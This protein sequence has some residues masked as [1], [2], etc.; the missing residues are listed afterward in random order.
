MPSGDSASWSATARSQATVDWE[1]DFSASPA[2]PKKAKFD[3][4]EGAA[5]PTVAQNLADDFNSKNK[6]SFSATATGAKVVFK[7][8]DSKHTVTGMRFTIDN[9]TDNLPGNGAD[10]TVGN[11]GM[12]VKRV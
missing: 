9:H 12:S 3:I 5:P 4:N 6:P 2:V 7:A 10:V 8:E 11:T 1:T